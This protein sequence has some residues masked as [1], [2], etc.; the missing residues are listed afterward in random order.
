MLVSLKHCLERVSNWQKLRAL[1]FGDFATTL[2]CLV[3]VEVSGSQPFMVCGPPL[4]DS[5]KLVAPRS[6]INLSSI[7]SRFLLFFRKKKSSVNL[8]LK[9][10][11]LKQDL[12]QL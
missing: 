7:F 1:E 12:H 5:S 4:R 3:T 11:S 6:S 10:L 9:F 8:E 2:F